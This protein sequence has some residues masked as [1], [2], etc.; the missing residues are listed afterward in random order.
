MQTALLHAGEPGVSDQMFFKVWIQ[1]ALGSQPRKG[2]F[3][4]MAQFYQ[5]GL[6][7]V[8]CG[9]SASDF[10]E[11]VTRSEP[12]PMRA[13]MQRAAMSSAWAWRSA[14]KTLSSDVK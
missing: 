8:A 14:A 13:S 1:R 12:G 5:R 6:W 4:I 9:V 10:T 2:A 3:R 11:I 7:R